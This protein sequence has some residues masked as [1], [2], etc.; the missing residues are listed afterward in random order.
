MK[1]TIDI[2]NNLIREGCYPYFY[3]GVEINGMLIP[4]KNNE[5]DTSRL[6]TLQISDL[7]SYYKS[8][9]KYL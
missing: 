8:I 3:N 7:T 9:E 5:I 2:L 4:L 6:T 1:K